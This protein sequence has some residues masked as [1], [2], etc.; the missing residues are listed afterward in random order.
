MLLNFYIF[1]AYLISPREFQKLIVD[2]GPIILIHK[3]L[4]DPLIKLTN[5]IDNYRH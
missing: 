5:Q 2:P 1:L 4:S 3:A